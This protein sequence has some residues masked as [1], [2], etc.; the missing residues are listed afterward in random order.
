[1]RID[2]RGRLKD[3]ASASEAAERVLESYGVD[4][5]CHG[6]ASLREACAGAGLDLGDVEHRLRECPETTQPHWDDVA[7][8]IDVI[9]GSCHVRTRA[10][11]AATRAAVEQSHRSG[12]AFRALIEAIDALEKLVIGQMNEEDAL[13]RRVRALAEARAS[14]GPYPAPPFTTVH[15]HGRRLR[16]GHTKIHDKLRRV[17]ALAQTPEMDAPALRHRV[18]ALSH[19]I[20]GQMHLENNE[21]LP[22]ARALEPE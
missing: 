8:L 5:C 4:F 9:V 17:R 3:I 13:F 12:A 2:P 1:M 15:V 19:A 11:L 7:N 10:A 16:A 6:D 21:L 20:V 22:R 18:D 14:R